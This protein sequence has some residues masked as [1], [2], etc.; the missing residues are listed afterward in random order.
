MSLTSVVIVGAGHA[1]VQAAASLREQ[2][3]DG[4]VVLLSAEKDPPYQRPPL[5]QGVSQRRNGHPWAPAQGRRAFPRAAHRPEARR[6]RDADRSRCAAGGAQRRK[7]DCLR[8]SHPCDWREAT[9]A[10]CAGSRSA[11]RV[12][13]P[14]HRRRD[15]DPRAAWREAQG[16]HHRRRIHRA[17]NRRDRREPRGRGDGGRDR[18]PDGPGGLADHVGFFPERARRLWGALPA[19]AWRHCDQGARARGNGHSHRRRGAERGPGRGR[20]SASSRKTRWRGI[21]ASNATMES[22]STSFCLPPIQRFRRSATAPI[23]RMRRLGSERV[24]NRCR[25]PSIRAARSPRVSWG[26]QNPTM[27]WPGSGAIRAT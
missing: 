19:W 11:G 6:R 9:A 14:R 20:A 25:T 16:C 13:A 2:G 22:W 17:R 21:A 10:R 23:F 4:E 7:R 3:F 27:N 15:R 18:A 8:T 26:S 24:S 1:G 12:R 5:V